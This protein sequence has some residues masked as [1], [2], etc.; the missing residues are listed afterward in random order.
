MIVPLKIDSYASGALLVATANAAALIGLLATRRPLRRLGM[1][2][3]HEVGGFLLSV[4]GTMYAVI[5]GLIVVDALAKFQSGRQTTEAEANALANIVLLADH[6]PP[7]ERDRIRSLAVSYAHLVI[8]EEWPLLDAGGFSGE[9]RSVALRLIDA[10]AGL[11][12]RSDREQALYERAI[13]ASEGLWDN[14]RM[15]IVAASHGIPRL[16]WFVLISG[17][18]ITVAFTYFF[19]VDHL[20]IQAA[21]TSLVATIIALNLYLVLMFGYPFSGDVKVGCDSFDIVPVIADRRGGP[22]AAPAP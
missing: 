5:L 10:L 13:E 8:D 16:E 1:I 6:L 14:R 22:P 20:R 21:M 11:E 15:R 3:H 4:V 12:P 17:G 9:A 18:M 2:S 7:A 19:R